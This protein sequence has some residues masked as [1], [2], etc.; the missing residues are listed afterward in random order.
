MLKSTGY[1]VTFEIDA[2]FNIDTFIKLRIAVT[3]RITTFVEEH[4]I[5]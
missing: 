5:L 3:K 4:S 1:E 2:C